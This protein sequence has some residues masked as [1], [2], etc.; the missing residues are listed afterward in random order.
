M[1]KYDFSNTFELSEEEKKIVKKRKIY[2]YFTCKSDSEKTHSVCRIKKTGKSLDSNKYYLISSFINITKKYIN[3]DTNKIKLE[4]DIFNGDTI[5]T[6]V[7]DR[8]ILTKSGIETLVQYGVCYDTDKPKRLL[9]YLL[10]SEQFAEIEYF[11]TQLGWDEIDGNKVFKSNKLISTDDYDL[12]SI[13]LGGLDLEP[14]GDRDKWFDMVKSEVIENIPLATV[15]LAGFASPILGYLNQKYDLGSILFNLSNSSS[16]GKT[17]AAMLATSVFGNPAIDKSTMITFNATNNALVSFASKCN[18]H[19]IA[20]DEA[21]ISSAS[22]VTK[23][24]YTLCAGRDKLRL[25]TDSELKEAAAFSSFIIST[26]EFDLIPDSATNGIR[27]RVFEL[28]DTFTTSAEN[29]VKI[30]ST[31]TENYGFAGNEFVEFLIKEKIN[32]IEKDYIKCQKVLLEHYFKK[33]TFKEKG[34]LTERVFSKLAIILQTAVYF[35]QCFGIEIKDEIIDYLLSIESNISK[36]S[37][38]TKYL[39]D[40]ILQFV[41]VNENKFI[42][43][44]NCYTCPPSAPWGRIIK[45]NSETEIIIL[46]S[47]ADEIFKDN[48]ISDAKNLLNIL[49]RKN[50]LDCESDRLCKRYTLGRKGNKPSCYIFKISRL[51]DN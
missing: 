8:S 41:A 51:F 38:R 26:A 35:K 17:T 42:T 44:Y 23:Q 7:F 20:L 30:K 15:M 36:N 47:K 13:Y 32:N 2:P 49:R 5:I 19:T 10:V 22:D 21:I 43:E 45:T 4:F 24:L 29:S 6:K 46:K 34:E 16:K 50:M 37:D 14:K 27:A 18:S 1:I 3:I 40:C 11:H 48:N 31:V 39:L 25:N 12:E 9:D 28:N 33:N